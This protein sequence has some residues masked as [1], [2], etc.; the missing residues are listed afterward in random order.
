MLHIGSQNIKVEYILNKRR[1]QKVNKEI[2]RGVG[3]DD[4]LKADNYTLSI[5]SRADRMIRWIVRNFISTKSI[6]FKYIKFK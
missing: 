2:I 5:V 1:I 4:I 6:F 3:L